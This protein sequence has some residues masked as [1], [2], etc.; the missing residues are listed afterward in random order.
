MAVASPAAENIRQERDLMVVLPVL[1]GRNISGDKLQYVYTKAPVTMVISD[2]QPTTHRPFSTKS[3]PASF[4]SKAQVF[5]VEPSVR[6]TSPHHSYY[7]EWVRN[8]IPTTQ[9]PNY[10]SVFHLAKVS[11]KPTNPPVVQFPSDDKYD[12]SVSKVTWKKSTDKSLVKWMGAEDV[13]STQSTAAAEPTL[14]I[15]TAN[16][17]QFNSSSA[18]ASMPD[19]KTVAQLALELQASTNRLTND[20]K[21]ML[22]HLGLLAQGPTPQGDS[23]ELGT[24]GSENTN[25]DVDSSSYMQFKNIPVRDELAIRDD[26]RQLLNSFGLL[27]P[28]NETNSTDEPTS[29]LKRD[30]K[31]QGSAWPLDVHQLF[32]QTVNKSSKSVEGHNRTSKSAPLKSGLENSTIKPLASFGQQRRR[33]KDQKRT[34]AVDTGASANK[35]E[36]KDGEPNSK[37]TASVEQLSGS[38]GGDPVAEQNSPPKQTN[39]LYFWVDWNKFFNL[40]GKPDVRLA[41]SSKA[42]DSTRFIPITDWRTKL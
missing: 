40:T 13:T 28:K 9:R 8:T 16:F 26:M 5:L 4:A 15:T 3:W 10:S 30:T 24:E 23:N 7:P 33:V 42:G 19:D 29:R 25:P 17:L 12:I 37:G 41:Y 21:S 22:L 2:T 14:D 36:S 38:F 32:S 6:R 18:N 27:P 34:R 1:Q 11:A 35:V 20:I 39:G 31:E